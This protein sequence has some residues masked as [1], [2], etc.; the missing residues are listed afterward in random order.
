MFCRCCWKAKKYLT[1]AD[2]VKMPEDSYYKKAANLMVQQFE[3]REKLTAEFMKDL[4]KCFGDL[5]NG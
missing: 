1:L 3:E 5:P 4:D 2:I